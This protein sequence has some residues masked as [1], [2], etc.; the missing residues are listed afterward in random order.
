MAGGAGL[1]KP[2]PNDHRIAELQR[3]HGLTQG[4]L[5]SKLDVTIPW[6]SRVER[7]DENLMVATLVKI[8]NAIGVEPREPWE[9]PGPGAPPV[10]RGRPSRPR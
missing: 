4:E 3:A 8:A 7:R 2:L 1:R 9:K 6:A 10:R 5:A